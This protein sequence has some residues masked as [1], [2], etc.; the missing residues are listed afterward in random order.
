MCKNLRIR[1]VK[2]PW[3]RASGQRVCPC[4]RGLLCEWKLRVILTPSGYRKEQIVNAYDFSLLLLAHTHIY[5]K[6]WPSALKVIAHWVRV[7]RMLKNKYDLTLC[8][9]CLHTASETSS[10]IR[11]FG[12]G[13]ILCVFASVTSILIG[14]DDEYENKKSYENVGHSVLGPLKPGYT[15]RSHRAFKV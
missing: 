9:S 13:S 5:R 8:Q 11:K 7:F 4:A 10:V 12:S 14:K 6:K 15:S 2:V 3:S 1:H